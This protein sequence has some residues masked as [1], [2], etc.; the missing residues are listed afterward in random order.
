MEDFQSLLKKMGNGQIS[1]SAYDTA[2][3]ARLTEYDSQISHR[4]LAWIAQNQLH[5]GGWGAKDVTYYHDRVICTLAAMIA[6]T[7]QGRREQDSWQ[8]QTGLSALNRII[9]NATG[10]LTQ[11]K[12]AATVGFEMIVPTLVLDAEKLGIIQHQGE[13]ILGRLGS[14]RKAKIEKL[15]GKRISRFITAAHS[16]EMAGIDNLN[17]L[18]IDGLQ[19]ENGSVANSPAATAY[20]ALSVKPGD[21]RALNYLHKIIGQDGSVPAF[22]PFDIFERVWVLWNL[23]LTDK[24]QTPEIKNLC[25][26]HIDYIRQEWKPGHGLGF[27]ASYTLTDGDDTMVGYEVLSKFGQNV[28]IESV[29][30]YEEE[31]W[32]RCYYLETHHSIDVNIHALGALKQAGFQSNHPTVKKALQFIKAVRNTGNYWFDKWHIS[33]Y[34][35]TAHAIISCREYADDL[36]AE[37]VSWI[38]ETQK[39]NGSWGFYNFSTAEETAYCLQALILWKRYGGKIPAGRIEQGSYWLANNCLPPYPPFWIDK[40]LYCPELLVQSSILSALALAEEE[41]IL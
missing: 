18:D 4:A 24:Y 1:S 7:R 20:F 38:L 19:E 17:L 41:E 15:S 26:P 29:L 28:D 16:A 14:A 13:R 2:W 34:Y 5:D 10:G 25:Q 37:S 21:A 35:T 27:S 11:E 12:R 8:V 33:P 30:N 39:P 32:F 3:L 31:N 9:Q 40:S 22:A 36:C 6:L 23:L